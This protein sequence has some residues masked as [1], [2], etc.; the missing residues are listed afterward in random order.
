M[1]TEDAEKLFAQWWAE[2]Y[3]SLPGP[4]ARMTHVAFAKWFHE[5]ALIDEAGEPA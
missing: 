3:G 2:S 4:H 5:Y 1:S